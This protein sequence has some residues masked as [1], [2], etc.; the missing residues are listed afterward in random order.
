[1]DTWIFTII[2]VSFAI[3]LTLCFVPLVVFLAIGGTYNLQDIIKWY[4][5]VLES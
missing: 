4:K 5:Y 2:F 3:L 1:M